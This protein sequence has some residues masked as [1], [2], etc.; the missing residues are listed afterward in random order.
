[1][2]ISDLL[3]KRKFT[4]FGHIQPEKELAYCIVTDGADNGKYGV[5]V[6]QYTKRTTETQA[7]KDITKSRKAAEKVLLFLYENAITPAV[8]PEI[9]HDIVMYD[10][11]EC[12]EF[13]GTADE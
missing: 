1:M 9:M 7:V 8:L 3:Y 12:G 11:F 5:A 13:G 10:V 2:E 4:A 6:T